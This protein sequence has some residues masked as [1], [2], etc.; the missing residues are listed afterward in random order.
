V[1]AEEERV[2]RIAAALGPRF[3]PPPQVAV[4][5]GTGL[6]EIDL[7]RASVEIPFREI[8]G[9]PQVAVEGHPGRLS[10]VGKAAV[11][12]G[13]AHYYEGYSLEEVVRPIRVL[14]LLG[15][16]ALVVT[17]AAGAVNPSLRPGDLMLLT[18]H[19]N[20]MGASPL[21][22]RNL[23]GVGGR[24]VDLSCAY[25]PALRKLAV[26]SAR[27]S[28]VKLRQGVYAAMP[29]PAYETPAEVRMLRRLG[30]DAVGMSTVPEAVAA[31]HAGMRVL[32]I[33]C[34][35]NRGAG[36]SRRPLT[37]AEVLAATRPAAAR[38][39]ALLRRILS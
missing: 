10:L 29:G 25:D 39:G 36:L 2:R 12:R 31:A 20:L 37:H 5:L 8:P 22:G 23:D 33:S 7:G 28:R 32:G 14:A 19:L 16:R 38:L 35:A 24:F 13:R 17:N 15:A 4:V 9:F 26:A 3:D 11:L 18:D 30:A 6:G 1:S 34:I 27:K 21:R